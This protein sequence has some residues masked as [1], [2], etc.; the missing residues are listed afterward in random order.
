MRKNYTHTAKEPKTRNDFIEMIEKKEDVI[1]L[2]HELIEELEKEIAKNLK[3]RKHGKFFTK[4]AVP[5]AILS[6][7]NPI[8]WLCSGIVFLSGKSIKS[9]DALKKYYVYSGYDMSLQK[10]L[11]FHLKKTVDI[12]YDDV[13]YPNWVKDVDYKSKK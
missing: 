9:S 8:G 1:V 3:D 10:I 13:T 12:K 4:V 7:S 2:N 11:I 6:L 5:M